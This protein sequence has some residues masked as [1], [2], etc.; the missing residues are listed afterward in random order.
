MPDIVYGKSVQSYTAWATETAYELNGYRVPTTDNGLCYKCTTAGTSGETEPNWIAKVGGTV[1]DGSAVWTCEEKAAA[2]NPLSVRL[3][4][5]G[6]GGAPSKDVWLKSDGNVTFLVEVSYTGGDGTWRKLASVNVNNTE[7]FQQYSTPYP[8]MK[9]ST[10][11]SASNEIE[12]V[13][14]E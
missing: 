8:H 6:Q 2:P 14:G 5:E 7:K 11:T 13:A 9:V 12:V 1:V 4:V 3:S 10:E